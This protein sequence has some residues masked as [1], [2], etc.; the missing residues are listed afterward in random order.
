MK[1]I[2]HHPSAVENKDARSARPLSRDRRRFL[3]RAAQAGA[4]WAFGSLFGSAGTRNAWAQNDAPGTAA[5][6]GKFTLL[7]R[8]QRP[9]NLETPIALLDQEITPNDAFFVRNHGTIPEVDPSTWRLT[10][11]GEL[12]RTVELS[13]DQLKRDYEVV[14][15]TAVLECAGNGRAFFKPPVRGNQWARGAIGCAAWTGVRLRDILRSGGLKPKAVYIGCYGADDSLNPG[16]VQPFSRGIPIAKALD[17]HTLVAFQMNGQDIP[18]PNGY[19][20]RL[21]VPGWVGS[22]SQK[23]LTRIWVRAEEHDT[24][25]MVGKAYRVPK[26]TIEPGADIAPEDMRVAMDWPVKSMITRPLEGSSAKAGRALEIRGF[27]WAGEH[28]VRRVELSFDG[29]KSWNNAATLKP[30]ADKYAWNRWSHDWTPTRAGAQEI[31]V[32]ATDDAGNTQPPEA[33]WNPGGYLGNA[34]HRV[35]VKIDA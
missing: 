34:I 23:W 25:F 8:G 21:I 18:K 6:P 2:P 5:Y 28:A 15:M 20:V 1:P 16:Q 4:L 14:T 26:R 33:P 29:G 19:P 11:E 10:V 24:P 9:L 22:A 27:A 31:W 30:A 3:I 35:P 12:L 13:L 32:R 17:E 7:D